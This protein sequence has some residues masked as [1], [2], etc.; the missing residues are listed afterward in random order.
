MFEVRLTAF[1]PL[2]EAV[3]GGSVHKLPD[4]SKYLE[5]S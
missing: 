3:L 1:D 5:T 4:I 2:R